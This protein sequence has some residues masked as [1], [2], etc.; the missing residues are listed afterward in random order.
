MLFAPADLV[1]PTRDTSGVVGQSIGV[2]HE[3]RSIDVYRFG[4]GERIVLLVGG[5][6][7]G[8]EANTV[9]L[10]RRMIAHFQANSAA[11][12][13]GTA[14]WIIPAANP[15]GLA[16]GGGENARFNARAVDLNRNW[17]CDWTSEAWWR[18]ARVNA[19]ATALSE[20]ETRALANFIIG[21]RPAAALFYH[22]AANGVFPGNCRGD[23]GSAAMAAVYGAA[24]GY[25]CCEAFTAYPVTGTAASWADGERIPAADVELASRDQPEFDVNLSGV[26]ALLA[27]A[28]GR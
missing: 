25:R 1:T 12:P 23:H 13:P 16:R 24:S 21:A 22:S 20:P 11:I 27:W 18:S 14:L 15:D 3:G 2:S 6:H 7:G 4:G 8:Y 28:A 9:V 5:L 26:L 10:M 17:S 19:G